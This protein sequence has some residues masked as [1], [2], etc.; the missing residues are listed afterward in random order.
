MEGQGA[1]GTEA[2]GFSKGV[3]F[4]LQANSIRNTLMETSFTAP[5]QPGRAKGHTGLAATLQVRGLHPG[6]PAVVQAK[7]RNKYKEKGKFN[8]S[9]GERANLCSDLAHLLSPILLCP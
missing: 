1:N 8:N 7:A 5:T 2:K 6:P 9:S 4:L 3:A